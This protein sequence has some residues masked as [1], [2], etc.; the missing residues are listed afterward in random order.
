MKML[1]SSLLKGLKIDTED[2]ML[3]AELLYFVEDYHKTLEVLNKGIGV[4]IDSMTCEKWLDLYE[5]NITRQSCNTRS[6]SLLM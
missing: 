1:A 4:N 3:K 5:A 2:Y 6:L